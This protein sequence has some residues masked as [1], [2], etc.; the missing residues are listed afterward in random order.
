MSIASEKV[1]HAALVG[2]GQ[3]ALHS[4]AGGGGGPT[5]KSGTVT[6][7]DGA[8]T[9]VTFGEAFTTTPKVIV[10]F[11]NIPQGVDIAYCRNPSTTQVIVG[12][13]KG[14]G[15]ATHTGN[16][17]SWIATDAGG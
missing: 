7:D 12:V 10:S 15:G 4:H 16:V 14:H 9:T 5:I 11:Q 6:L 13:Y 3:T 17:I 2:G 8:E 1:A